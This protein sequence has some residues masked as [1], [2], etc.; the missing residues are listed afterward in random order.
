MSVALQ[1]GLSKGGATDL[2]YFV[3]DLLHLDGLD[4]TKPPNRLTLSGL[5]ASRPPAMDPLVPLHGGGHVP[6]W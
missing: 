5:C 2:V 3:F 4:L 6:R 1:D